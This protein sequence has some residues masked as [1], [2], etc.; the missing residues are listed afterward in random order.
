MNPVYSKVIFGIGIILSVSAIISIYVTSIAITN[1]DFKP[2]PSP[3]TSSSSQTSSAQTSST[4][5]TKETNG[6]TVTID[7]PQ[8]AGNQLASLDNKYYNPNTANVTMGNTITWVNKDIAPHTAT[9]GKDGSDPSSG[10][11]FDTGEIQPGSSKS[12]T[13]DQKGNIPYY[14]TIHPW[15]VGSSLN[16]S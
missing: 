9:S 7:I 16:V 11:I 15:M 14:C 4:S 1:Q 6:Q 10:K 12:I 13:I 5:N 8:G 2:S 3:N